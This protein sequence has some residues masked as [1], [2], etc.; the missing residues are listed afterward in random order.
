MGNPLQLGKDLNKLH[1]PKIDWLMMGLLLAA[2]GFGFLPL[3]VIDGEY[4]S[5]PLIVNKIIQVIFG[6]GITV[7]VM[8]LDYRK[9]EKYRM[10]FYKIGCVFLLFIIL[11]S[12]T[13]VNGYS[14]IHIPGLFEINAYYALPFFFVGWA[15][16]LNQ[17]KLTV[18]YFL[19]LWIFSFLLFYMSNQSIIINGLYLMMILVM[20]WWSKL[21]KKKV[22]WILSTM[23]AIIVSIV[24]I[25]L[26]TVKE[27]QLTRL[28]AFLHPNETNGGYMY[29]KIKEVLE[30][31]EWIGASKLFVLPQSHT[32][33]AF[34]SI[35]NAY[36]YIAGVLLL[37]VL[38]VFL[39]RLIKILHLVQI[40]NS[41]GKL[42]VIGGMV[43][44]VAP[45]VYNIGMVVGL[46]PI[47]G[48][49]LPFIS[50]G[51]LSIF[52]HA[53]GIGIALSIYRR[54]DLQNKTI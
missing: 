10:N 52:L 29:L 33:F 41:Y 39:L 42:L 54:K 26:S 20:L 43:L 3:S 13:Q 45:V 27:Y 35:V 36:G 16:I 21:D 49:Y 50:Y 15:G 9:L 37:V 14:Y 28:Y 11:F 18:W 40:Q 24:V 31:A 46:L 22:I 48:M 53:I 51:M 30:N 4:D 12:N 23:A 17:K 7:G 32:D 8:L 47:I 1:R 6:V 5:Y 34:V 19:K 38:L 44:Y 2:F 25:L